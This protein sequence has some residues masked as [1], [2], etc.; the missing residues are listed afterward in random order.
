[1]NDAA[2]RGGDGPLIVDALQMPVPERR[3]LEEWHAGGVGCV[4]CTL[5][6]WESARETLSIIGRWRRL[7]D[8]SRDLA[9]LATSAADIERIAGEGRTAVIFGFQN[10][11]PVEHDIEL[12][13]IFR[14]L[15]VCIM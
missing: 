11:A 14:D 6:I 1:M 8:E 13:G 5:A 9:A 3:W 12:F 4:H 7:L 15:G 10:T 2:A